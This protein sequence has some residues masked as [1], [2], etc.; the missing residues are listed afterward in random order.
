MILRGACFLVLA[1]VCTPALTGCSGV[2]LEGLGPD[3][4][5][6][7]ATRASGPSTRSDGGTELDARADV[8]AAPIPGDGAAPFDAISE[9]TP[10]ATTVV[11]DATDD[12]RVDAPPPPPPPPVDCDQDGD[13]YPAVGGGCNGEDCCDTDPNAHPGQSAYFTQADRCGSFDYDCT[14]S[15]IPEYL[16]VNCQLVFG[17]CGGD[18]FEQP[19]ACGATAA[20]SHCSLGFLGCA[21]TS[22]MKTQ[23]CR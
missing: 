19:Q 2:G 13:G 8:D 1:T 10:E 21:T 22:E 15:I 14:G 23:G 5:E 3:P 4:V 20:F 7:G 18:G 11:V 17:G 16:Q 6:G 12:A 9:P